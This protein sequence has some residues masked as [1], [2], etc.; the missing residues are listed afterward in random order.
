MPFVQ[1]LKEGQDVEHKF[2]ELLR[3]KYEIEDIEFPPE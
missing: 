2:A 1:D 3:E